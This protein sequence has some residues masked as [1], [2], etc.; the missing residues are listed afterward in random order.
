M[1]KAKTDE[2]K[3]CSLLKS[4]TE[5]KRTIENNNKSSCRLL[6]KV[7]CQKSRKDR[8][9]MNQLEFPPFR[10]FMKTCKTTHEIYFLLQFL[11]GMNALRQ[12]IDVYK[13]LVT[14]FTT[15]LLYNCIASYD[16][17]SNLTLK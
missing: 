4:R 5:Q 1:W 17:Q 11:V 14:Y 7:K 10:E 13:S 12:I 8:L 15:A 9:G 6:W 3:N 16:N 2:S